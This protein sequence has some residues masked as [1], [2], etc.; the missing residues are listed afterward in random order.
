MP[1]KEENWQRSN[2]IKKERQTSAFF[3]LAHK[4][5]SALFGTLGQRAILCPALG[6]YE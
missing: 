6:S 4:Q 3:I 1:N 2:R 5:V